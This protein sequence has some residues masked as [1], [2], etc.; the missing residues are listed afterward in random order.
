MSHGLFATTI[1]CMDGRT[2]LPVN[3]FLKTTFHVDFIDTITEPGPDKILA[4]NT[5]TLII[6]NIK[7]RVLI[8]TEKHG[9][10]LIAIVAHDD[11]AGNPVDRQIH[12]EHLKK[13]RDT[14]VSWNLPDVNVITLWV[15]EN[16][17]VHQI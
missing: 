7:K 11:C 2:Q 1:N 3:N 9:S 16:W 12:L 10:K 13:S 6:E 8:S 5:N 4:E 15:D 14:I 17:Q